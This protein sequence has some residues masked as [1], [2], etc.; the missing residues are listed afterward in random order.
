MSLHPLNL[1]HTCPNVHN[2]SAYGEN[3]DQSCRTGKKNRALVLVT[4]AVKDG[5]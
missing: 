1:R 3:I 4:L 5:S 2:E